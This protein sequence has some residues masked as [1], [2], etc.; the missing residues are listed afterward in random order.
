MKQTKFGKKVVCVQILHIFW[1]AHTEYKVSPQKREINN[2]TDLDT[3][4][5]GVITVDRHVHIC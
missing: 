5:E 4:D 1:H 2:N 3:A